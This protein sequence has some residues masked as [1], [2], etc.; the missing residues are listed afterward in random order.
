M[1]QRYVASVSDGC[2][3]SRL[4]YCVCY[5]GRT[6]ILQ[7]YVTNVSSVFSERMLQVG[8]SGCCICFTHVF[9]LDVAYG[10]NVFQV[11]SGGFSSVSS[12]FKRMLI[13]ML[14]IFTHVFYLDVAY[15]C[16]VFQVFSGGF[17]SV[18]SAFRRML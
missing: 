14:H 13:W 10:C 4:R 3:K 12:A 9:Y 11:F 17:S 1:F 5:N 6:L 16:N 18:S 2:Y 7:R 15:G 8:L